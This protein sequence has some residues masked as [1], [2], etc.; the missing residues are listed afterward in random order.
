MGM[1]RDEDQRLEVVAQ[2]FWQ[3]GDGGQQSPIF[4]VAQGAGRVAE[5]TSINMTVD[6][7]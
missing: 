4:F 6:H 7:T 2:A 3:R 5:T 1:R